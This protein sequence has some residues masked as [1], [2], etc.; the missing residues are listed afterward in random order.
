MIIDVRHML[1]MMDV[2]SYRGG[3]VDSDHYLVTA[4]MRVRISNI[5]K[6]RGKIIRKF[7]ISKLQDENMTNMYAKRLE[8]SL[9]QLSC[10]GGETVQ[11]EW[12]ICKSTIQQ[13]AEEVLVRQVSRQRNNWFDKD[14]E[15]ASKEKNDAYLIMQQQ[16]GTRNKVLRYQEKRREENT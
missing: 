15:R 3:N 5:K 11:E 6:I 12:D 16:H 8:E 2:I 14:C 1:D 13:V 9:K 7:C 4:R 10:S